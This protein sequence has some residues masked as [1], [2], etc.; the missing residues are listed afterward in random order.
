MIYFIILFSSKLQ[1]LMTKEHINYFEC[2]S[3]KLSLCLLY[4][5]VNNNAKTSYMYYI[6]HAH[7]TFRILYFLSL[8]C[9]LQKVH[10]TLIESI[11]NS[12]KVSFVGFKNTYIT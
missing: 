4:F 1:D 12:I 2:Q 3:M 8:S 10:D 7:A 6:S 11:E 9:N 5:C